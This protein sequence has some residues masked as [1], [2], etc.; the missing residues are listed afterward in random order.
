M[1]EKRF[2]R[3]IDSMMKRV[4]E[5]HFSVDIFLSDNGHPFNLTTINRMPE[6]SIVEAHLETFERQGDQPPT[7]V[8][9]DLTEL[10]GIEVGKGYFE[11]IR[12]ALKTHKPH[13]PIAPLLDSL[14]ENAR[15]VFQLG[16]LKPNQ[17]EGMDFSDPFVVRQLDLMYWPGLEEGCL[18]YTKEMEGQFKELGI[19]AESR[20]D[21]YAPDPRQ[22]YRFRRDKIIECR[23][24]EE[25]HNLYAHL[26]DDLHE[27]EVEM[28]IS[29]ESQKVKDIHCQSIRSPYP[30][31]CNLPFKQDSQL[32]GVSIDND[33]RNHVVHA[34]G[35]RKGCVHLADLITDLI[36]YFRRVVTF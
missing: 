11:K 36:L 10:R 4:D 12:K 29:P 8:K 13:K 1:K 16:I 17:V 35:D 2:R 7:L 6:R 27:M 31:I 34:V 14:I 32:L 28:Q 15:M 18:P 19:R 22:I 33:I 24:T 26:S 25:K 23:L 20:M 30:G 21:I 3:V 5:T 9:K